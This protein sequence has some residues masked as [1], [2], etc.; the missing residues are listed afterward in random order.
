MRI[1]LLSIL[2]SSLLC[3][4]PINIISGLRQLFVSYLD[5][6]ASSEIQLTGFILIIDN[7]GYI[8]RERHN[9]STE[10]WKI[11]LIVNIACEVVLLEL[12]TALALATIVIV[13]RVAVS[14]A[15]GWWQYIAS[16]NLHV[17][18]S[19]IAREGIV[20][21]GFDVA[22]GWTKTEH[23]LCIPTQLV[24]T[25]EVRSTIIIVSKLYFIILINSL[26]G[27][28]IRRLTHFRE[29]VVVANEVIIWRLLCAQSA[30]AVIQ[31]FLDLV[32]F[33]FNGFRSLLSVRNFEESIAVWDL[34]I[35]DVVVV[36]STAKA[37]SC[38]VEV[39]LSLVHAG[40]SI[41]F[42]GGSALV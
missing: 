5:S 42:I 9:S 40:A 29:I 1:V 22:L 26:I 18:V 34:S 16:A 32:E 2:S 15:P 23:F 20:I 33:R 27:I 35:G 41:V 14:A 39:G 10:R 12:L 19:T 7:F 3:S 31:S 28:V 11:I 13:Q 6:A 4:F 38:A 24:L 8:L 36:C 17:L 21:V 37:R 25:S 30:V